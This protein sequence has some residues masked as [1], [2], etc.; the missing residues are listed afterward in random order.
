MNNI[1]KY[2]IGEVARACGISVRR[3]RYLSDTGY[4][5]KPPSVICGGIQYRYYTENDIK[6]I[7]IIRNYQDMGLPLNIDAWKARDEQ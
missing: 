5:D 1:K 2:S 7:E 6:L 3:V 4:I